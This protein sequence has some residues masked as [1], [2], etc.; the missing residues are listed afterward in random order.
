MGFLFGIPRK[1]IRRVTEI[2][3]DTHYY[4]KDV[5][6][7]NQEYFTYTVSRFENKDTATITG[8][9]NKGIT[10][11]V[12]PYKIRIGDSTSN[13]YATITKLDSAA[14]KN[15]ESIETITIPNTIHEISDELFSGCTSLSQ[16]NIPKSINTIGSKAF[17]NCSKLDTLF[18]PTSVKEIKEDAFEGCSTL[19]II[20][21]KGSK[22]EEFAKLH[23]IPYSLISYTLDSDIKQNSHN[24]V[25]SGTI[26]NHVQNLIQK[27]NAHI[28]NKLNPHDDS[29][30][31]NSTLSGNTTITQGTVSIILNDDKSLVN[32]EY[33]LNSIQEVQNPSTGIRY[34]K[35]YDSNLKTD[36]KTIVGAIN[37]LSNKVNTVHG[38]LKAGWNNVSLNLLY[39]LGWMFLNKPYAYTDD[40]INVDY[41]IKNLAVTNDTIKNNTNTFDIYVPIDCNYTFSTTNSNEISGYAIDY[42]VISYY[43][44]G[45]DGKDLDT[46]TGVSNKNW[47]LSKNT[48]GYGHDKLISNSSNVTLIH[49][50]GD[51]QGGGSENASTKYYESIYFNINAIQEQ[52]S[53]EDI[54][55]ILYGV[56]YNELGDGNIHISMDCYSSPNIPTIHENSNRLIT[57]TGDDLN[58]T[59]S[60]DNNLTC[61]IAAKG[62]GYASNYET[63]YTPA[64]KITFKKVVNDS[65]HRTIII[66]PLS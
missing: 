50:G 24:L 27:I 54:D 35:E 57:L 11:S 25:T 3:I 5:V 1:L 63:S 10:T 34:Q 22:A 66:K 4:D 43:Y 29:N 46:V 64:F 49:W 65:N 37:E 53:N 59:Y 2:E 19:D 52:L 39:P 44:T 31:T 56:W 47:P 9:K 41:R 48:V 21:Y 20:C 55:I 40:G 16:C 51:N 33:V 28:N 18:I 42:L 15:Y 17:Y 36:A 14:F 6:P 45:A 60:S 7:S 62:K 32:K 61:Y 23:N 8:F 58:K 30:F 38:T 26:W 12:I 13:M